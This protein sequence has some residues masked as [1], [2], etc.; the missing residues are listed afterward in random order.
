LEKYGLGE[1]K[2]VAHEKRKWYE[3]N[4]YKL[5]DSY[6]EYDKEYFFG[7]DGDV[8]ELLELVYGPLTSS[9]H[10]VHILPSY[11][12]KSDLRRRAQI[13]MSIIQPIVMIE[14]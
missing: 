14:I 3:F 11:P 1:P 12:I 9:N 6:N 7:R 5:L 10:R 8:T 4:P 13:T 2:K